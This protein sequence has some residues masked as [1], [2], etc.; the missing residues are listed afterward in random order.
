MIASLDL[1]PTPDTASPRRADAFRPDARANEKTSAAEN[2]SFARHFV[3]R[4]AQH[5]QANAD[6]SIALTNVEAFVQE[7]DEADSTKTDLDP[8]NDNALLAQ[9]LLA[10]LTP[11]ANSQPDAGSGTEVDGNVADIKNVQEDARDTLNILR[12]KTITAHPLDRDDARRLN[13]PSSATAN[14]PSQASS[15]HLPQTGV[16]GQ[17]KAN[18]A[19]LS[20]LNN[21]ERLP[22]LTTRSLTT[23][24]SDLSSLPGTNTTSNPAA[25]DL[26]FL[27]PATNT[28]LLSTHTASASTPTPLLS[29]HIATPLNQAGWGQAVMHQVAQTLAH[30]KQVQHAQLQLN[31]PDL[32]ALHVTLRIEDSVAQAWFASPH[33]AV[34]E[35]VQSALPDLAQ[36]LN[37]AGMALGDA[38]VGSEQRPFEHHA[39]AFAHTQNHSNPQGQ[40]QEH[41]PHAAAHPATPLHAPAAHSVR[42]AGHLLVDTYA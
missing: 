35:A 5:E 10:L 13:L 2:A 26:T 37:E 18:T 8:A 1:S 12:M 7:Q 11:A 29:L 3:Q 21:M 36:H 25:S 38:Q 34:R 40:G 20:V 23:D 39:Q 6:G 31:P 28:T 15:A 24:N 4:F 27:S 30:G 42:P 9:P 41:D 17:S 16:T 32:G 22:G 19:L 33:A 14:I